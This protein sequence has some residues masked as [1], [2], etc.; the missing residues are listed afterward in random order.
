MFS[1]ELLNKNY[2]TLFFVLATLGLKSGLVLAGQAL[3]HLSHA[4]S[5]SLLF[6]T[7]FLHWVPTDQTLKLKAESPMLKFHITTQK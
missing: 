6:L 3:Y 7:K 2:R 5:L 4:P 1:F